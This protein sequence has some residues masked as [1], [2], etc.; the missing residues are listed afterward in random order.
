M[1]RKRNILGSI[2]VAAFVTASAAAIFS[3]QKPAEGTMTFQREKTI[4]VPE[5]MQSIRH[6]DDTFFYVTSEMSFDGKLVKGAPYSAQAV[7]EMTQML[8][9]GNRI[10]NKST[11]SIY[12]DSEGRTRRE[13]T[14][15]AIGP[16]ATASE[17]P[18]TIF[19]SDPVAQM[20]YVLDAR[21]H[22]ARKMPSFRFEVNV[23]PPVKGIRLAA[24]P[25][26]P[27]P[28]ARPDH[29]QNDPNI[30][31]MTTPPVPGGEGYRVE[32]HGGGKRAKA[33]SMDKQL[34]EGVEAEGTRTTVTIPAGQ[35]GNERAIEIVS[36]R[37]YSPELQTVVMTKHSDP[38]FG[39]TVYRL[40]NISRSEQPRSLFEVPG[41][42]TVKSPSMGIGSGGGGGVGG[43]I[44]SGSGTT[45]APGANPALRAINGGVLNG[46]ATSLPAPEF[47]PIAR[48]AR[49]SGR[50]TVQITID[51]DG[52]VISAQADSGHPLLRAAAVTAA[53]EAKFSPTQLSGQPVKVQGV[54]I[55]N[56]SPEE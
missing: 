15:R 9:D 55:Y 23:A 6:P 42:Y 51:E 1:N 40:T 4:Q 45:I 25:E 5:E 17:P 41:D 3:Q 47:P 56:F 34:I 8:I 50:V 7:T 36:E 39:E 53:R 19:I 43:G 30:F 24:P 21:T 54:V 10:V 14:L 29:G 32:Y 16:F 38:R 37:W 27:A 46:K 33:E 18:Q 12:R 49:A 26:G 28:P 22:V 52:N 31:V 35:I 20:S 44:G 48:A 13:Q 2:L 11:V